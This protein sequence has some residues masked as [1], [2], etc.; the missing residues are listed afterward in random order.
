MKRV[1]TT[2]GL[3]L[4]ATMIEGDDVRRSYQPELV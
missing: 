2:A 3:V 1:L 4:M